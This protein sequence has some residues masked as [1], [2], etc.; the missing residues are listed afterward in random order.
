MLKTSW[1]HHNWLENKNQ[2]HGLNIRLARW[3]LGSLHVLTKRSDWQGIRK[4]N[5]SQH[6]FDPDNSKYELRQVTAV[7]ITN[8]IDMCW[9]GGFGLPA[10]AWP[11]NSSLG[12]NRLGWFTVTYQT[13]SPTQWCT[14]VWPGVGLEGQEFRAMER[15]RNHGQLSKFSFELPSNL[16]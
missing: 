11:L 1:Q 10:L 3:H 13:A 16:H 9:T 2:T 4:Y 14:L 6:S 15:N 5:I 7:T 12:P 8:T